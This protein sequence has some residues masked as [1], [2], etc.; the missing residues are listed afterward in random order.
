MLISSSWA[1]LT[2]SSAV[3]PVLTI[4]R[5]LGTRD[6]SSRPPLHKPVSFQLF[7]H[8][9][10]DSVPWTTCECVINSASPSVSS[11]SDLPANFSTYNRVILRC[12]AFADLRTF[13]KILSNFLYHQLRSIVFIVTSTCYR[14]TKSISVVC[15]PPNHVSHRPG[16]R[17][18]HD[19]RPCWLR[20]P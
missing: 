14:L 13:R 20:S 6:L 1:A 7:V 8:G 9:L 15:W 11:I 10:L 18:R 3:M 16:A 4:V 17:G 19:N 2:I 12:H 5:I